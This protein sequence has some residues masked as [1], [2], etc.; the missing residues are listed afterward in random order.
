MSDDLSTRGIERQRRSMVNAAE[1]ERLAQALRDGDTETFTRAI[2]AANKPTAPT[3]REARC[4]WRLSQRCQHVLGHDGPH[5]V[6]PLKPFDFMAPD[7]SPY[8]ALTRR[9]PLDVERL[10]R[11]LVWMNDSDP[12]RKPP[13]WDLVGE[14]S[15]DHYRKQ[16]VAIAAEYA[17]LEAER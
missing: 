9:E 15:R 6:M 11:A 5:M 17:R 3:P 12:T 1:K 14:Q 16:A 2:R 13:L 10:A 8:P 4:D 7:G